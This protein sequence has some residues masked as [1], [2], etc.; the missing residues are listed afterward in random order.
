MNKEY[1]SKVKAEKY[2]FE[3]VQDIHADTQNVLQEATGEMDR[4]ATDFAEAKIVL[5]DYIMEV[6]FEAG[7]LEE[8]LLE[9]ENKLDEIGVDP[10]S[11]AGWREAADLIQEIYNVTDDAAEEL[12]SL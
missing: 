7:R 9:I 10:N 1:L 11:V 6:N 3:S 5:E 2:K 4:R 8:R 12:S